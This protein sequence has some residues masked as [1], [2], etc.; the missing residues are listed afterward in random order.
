MLNLIAEYFMINSVIGTHLQQLIVIGDNEIMTIH[1]LIYFTNYFYINVKK[2]IP[3]FFSNYS[4]YHIFS[5]SVT[6]V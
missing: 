1:I 2:K 5:F 4:Y 3:I 6:D